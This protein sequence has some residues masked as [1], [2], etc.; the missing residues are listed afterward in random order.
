MTTQRQ[1]VRPISTFW[2][3]HKRSYFIFVMR[4]L[5]S[6]FVA[7]FVFYLLMFIGA[8]SRGEAA[9]QDFLNGADHPAVVAINVVAFG[10]LVLHLV[11]W[12]SLTPKAMVIQVGGRR[13][14]G[15]AILA[16][17]YVGLVVVSAFV[18][19]LVTR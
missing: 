19:W 17:Q 2:W 14:P 12:F 4:E 1:Y 3:V 5:S 10:F 15:P 18:Y 7:W 16:S 6:F 8:V 13:V 11:T 9:Y